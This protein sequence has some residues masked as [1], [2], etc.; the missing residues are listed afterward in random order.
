V[1]T[2]KAVAAGRTRLLQFN[3]SLVSLLYLS[4]VFELSQQAEATAISSHEE[5]AVFTTF[6]DTAT[7]IHEQ[8]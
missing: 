7:I 4:C 8:Q 1:R 2:A 6:M 5:Y 3:V